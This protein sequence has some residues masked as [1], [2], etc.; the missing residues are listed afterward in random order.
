[1]NVRISSRLDQILAEF[2]AIGKKI[3]AAAIGIRRNNYEMKSHRTYR[4][5]EWN[6]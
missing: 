4:F 5:A 3:R 1:M 6:I 2:D